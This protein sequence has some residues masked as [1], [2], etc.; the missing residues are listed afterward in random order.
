MP[1]ATTTAT[2]IAPVEDLAKK[3]WSCEPL[4]KYVD[5]SQSFSENLD[6]ALRDPMLILFLA[7]CGLWIVVSGLKLALRMTEQ[8]AIIKDLAYIT[9]T[10]VLLGS[11]SAGLVSTVYSS[12]LD[13]MGG[14]SAAVFGFAG[15]EVKSSGYTGLVALAANGEQAVTIVFQ[16]AGA[17]ADAGGPTNLH[18]YI[19]AIVL[20]VPY[21]LL[22][23][24]YSSQVVVAIF[25]ATMVAVFSPFLFMA[26]AFGWGRGMAMSGAKTLLSAVLVLFA[27]T[28]ALALCIYG[29]TA[30]QLRPNG[31]LGDKIIDFANVSNPAFLVIL[32]LGW[33]GTALMAE[34][35]SI[36]N[37]IAQTALTNAAAGIMTAGVSASAMMG[38]KKAGQAAG[39]AGNLA[40]GAAS[41]GSKG[42][43]WGQSAMADPAAAG[44]DL[45]ERFQTINKKIEDLPR[46]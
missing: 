6:S 18:Y 45:V 17:L 28:A 39:P 24:A 30:L 25:R 42:F 9:I 5:L 35:T 1:T 32:F 12:A 20:V 33:A 19:Y 27:S 7:L 43:F 34:G 38:M 15:G 40:A 8:T 11:Q 29:V 36:A 10:G 31:L 46:R 21:F 3:C 16:A 2:A 44:R 14:A 4:Q 26:F 23:V 37:S 22:V 41:A 13:V